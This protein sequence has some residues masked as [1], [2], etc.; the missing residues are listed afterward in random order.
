LRFSAFMSCKGWRIGTSVF[1]AQGV[2]QFQPPPLTMMPPPGIVGSYAPNGPPKAWRLP[3]RNSVWATL[4]DMSRPLI[5]AAPAPPQA[6][7]L[8]D[9]RITLRKVA[10]M[11]RTTTQETCF[12]S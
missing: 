2:E 11:R 10:P 4:H 6:L 12:A 1:F 9:H 7:G 3:T 8:R 5:M